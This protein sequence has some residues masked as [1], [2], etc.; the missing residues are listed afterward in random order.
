MVSKNDS[1]RSFFHL[2][3]FPSFLL[4]FLYSLKGNQ[5]FNRSMLL[6]VGE[7]LTLVFFQIFFLYRG[8]DTFRFLNGTFKGKWHASINS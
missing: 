7:V 5:C 4:W 8:K 1:P 6:M 2:F 3:K